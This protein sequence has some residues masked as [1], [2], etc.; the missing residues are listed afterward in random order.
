MAHPSAQRSKKGIL[1]KP[2]PPVYSKP[3]VQTNPIL[4]NRATIA[5]V[6]LTSLIR[7]PKAKLFGKK[8][9]AKFVLDSNTWEWNK[10]NNLLMYRF[11]TEKR[12]TRI[13]AFDFDGCL[14]KTSLYQREPDAWSVLFPKKTEAVLHELSDNG[15]KLVI[16]SNQGGIGRAKKSKNEE[17][18]KVKTRVTSFIGEMQSKKELPMDVLISTNKQSVFHKPDVGMWNFFKENLN[19]DVKI[20]M[21]K[22]FYVGDA[23]G[24]RTDFA[25]SDAKFAKS[26]GLQF[27]N[28]KQF[29]V[30]SGYKKL[31]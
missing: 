7:R 11:G 12:S 19:G 24:R 27:F 30:Q 6:N 28:E 3:S 23:A 10:S 5:G 20:D 1:P 21:E 9:S 16:I 18:S 22:S 25:D 15:Y 14:V 17:I 29:F 26:A 4:A 31:L 8:Q 13:A 2:K